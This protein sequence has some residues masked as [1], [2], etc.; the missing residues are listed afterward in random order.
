M[1]VSKGDLAILVKAMNINNIGVTVQVIRYYGAFY[2]ENDCWYIQSSRPLSGIDWDGVTPYKNA[3]DLVAPDSWLRRISGPPVG[4][5]IE[6][7]NP[8]KHKEPV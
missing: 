8:I 1:N 5:D 6:T 4:E 7:D 2:S 3:M